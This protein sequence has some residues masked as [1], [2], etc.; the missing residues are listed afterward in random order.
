MYNKTLVRSLYPLAGKQWEAF[1]HELGWLLSVS[2]APINHPNL[3]ARPEIQRRLNGTREGLILVYLFAM[4]EQFVERSVETQWL[5]QAELLRLNAFRHL[6]HCAA[7][8]FEGRRAKQCRDE[9][10][11]IMNSTDPFQNVEWTTDMV[12]IS[13]GNVAIHC[14]QFMAGLAPQ[15][16]SRI[17]E[18]REP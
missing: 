18:G 5:T 10:E 7:H 4:W 3:Q 1:Q 2:T 15:L 11:T 16:I 12:D 13:N 6:R 8:G 9:F 17:A 14:Q